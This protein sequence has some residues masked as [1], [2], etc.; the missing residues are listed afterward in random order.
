MQ[1]IPFSLRRLAAYAPS[2][3]LHSLIE[4]AEAKVFNFKKFLH[5]I[6]GSLTTQPRLLNTA[7]RRHLIGNQ[8]GVD[9]HHATLEA[10]GRT[11]DPSDIPAVKIARQTKFRVVR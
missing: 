4:T 10:L 7:K 5:A 2:S 9:P 3:D 11:P 6:T 8:P 1:V